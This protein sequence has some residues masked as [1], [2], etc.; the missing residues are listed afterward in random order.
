[1][2]QQSTTHPLICFLCAAMLPLQRQVSWHGSM[3]EE[4]LPN[5]QGSS[6]AERLKAAAQSAVKKREAPC[7]HAAVNYAVVTHNAM[8]LWSCL[9]GA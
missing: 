6:L 8:S 9:H 2:I 3:Q 7:L 5:G 1:M 4:E